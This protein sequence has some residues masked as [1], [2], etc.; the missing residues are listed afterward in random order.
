MQNSRIWRQ[1]PERIQ[2]VAEL[3]DVFEKGFDFRRSTIARRI[4]QF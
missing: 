4:R 2:R 1:Q 3:I